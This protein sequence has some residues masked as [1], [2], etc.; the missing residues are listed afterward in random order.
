MRM[1][2]PLK[3][4]AR[5]QGP[6]RAGAGATLDPTGPIGILVNFGKAKP[7]EPDAVG[8]PINRTLHLMLLTPTSSPMVI[9]MGPS[10]YRI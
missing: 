8:T 10:I 3:H 7:I 9:P 5:G 4:Q 2:M 1:L 6:I